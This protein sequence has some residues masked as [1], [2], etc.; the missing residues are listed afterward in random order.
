MTLTMMHGTSEESSIKI[1]GP[2][3][4]LIG[5][6]NFAGSGIYF[7]MEKRVAMHYAEASAQ[8]KKKPNKVNLQICLVLLVLNVN[9]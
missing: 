5:D 1:S 8:N 3:R 7:T 9:M 6:G 2:G 4:W